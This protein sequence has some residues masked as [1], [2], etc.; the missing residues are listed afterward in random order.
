MNSH[1]HYDDSRLLFRALLANG[2]FSSLSGLIMLLAA[3]PVAQM[4]GIAE[5]AW[6][7]GLGAVLLVF[8]GS[9]LLHVY[10]RKVR[11]VEAVAISAMDLGWV[12]GSALL[13]LLV[14]ELF[15]A[16]GVVAVL[17]VAAIVFA[18]FELQAYALWKAR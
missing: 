1:I 5:P 12:I 18:F 2:V 14:P 15:S 4:I 8:G 6:L 3:G 10:R 17:V 9:L 13:L 7:R 16:T 11:R